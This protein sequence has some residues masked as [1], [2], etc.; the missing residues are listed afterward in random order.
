MQ[1][2]YVVRHY[3]MASSIRDAIKQSKGR[4]PDEAYITDA[5]MNKVGF[6]PDEEKE[7]DGFKQRK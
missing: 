4:E 7:T 3:V 1:K 6:I 5:W 2:L